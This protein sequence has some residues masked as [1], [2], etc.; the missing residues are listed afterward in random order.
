MTAAKAA[1]YRALSA[2]AAAIMKENAR[3]SAADKARYVARLAQM[4][5]GTATQAAATFAAATPA[6]KA[7]LR[8]NFNNPKYLPRK[9]AKSSPAPSPVEAKRWA[10]AY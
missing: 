6:E 4:G 5:L 7:T 3:E 2:T 1:A 9:V 10:L 8:K